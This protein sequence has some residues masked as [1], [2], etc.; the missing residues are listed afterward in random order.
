MAKFVCKDCGWEGKPMFMA[1]AT[2]LCPK[3]RGVNLKKVKKE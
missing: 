2:R 1:P 3:C